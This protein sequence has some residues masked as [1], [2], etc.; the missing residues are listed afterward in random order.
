MQAGEQLGKRA[1]ENRRATGLAKVEAD[2]RKEGMCKFDW[3]NEQAVGRVDVRLGKDRAA[4][5]VAK[6]AGKRA[7]V[8]AC[9]RAGVWA[10]RRVGV[11][12]CGRAGVWACRRVGV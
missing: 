10:Y 12:A 4:E 11:Q 6:R 9:G 3:I 5:Q 7:S 8:Q 2:T 1:L